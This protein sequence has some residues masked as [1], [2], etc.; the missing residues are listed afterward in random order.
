MV[1]QTISHYRIVEK[2]GGGGMGVVYKAEDIK[3]NRF[4][5]LKFLPE[6][7]AHDPHALERFRREAKAASAL[8]HPNICTIY[9][10][11]EQNGQAFIA[12]EFMDGVT[13]KHR[14]GGKPMEI[15][16][17]LSLGI[18]IADA[19]DSAHSAGIVHRDIKPANIFVTKRGHAKILD[20]GLAKVTAVLSDTGEAGATAPSTVTLEDHLTSPGTAVG[21]VAYMSPEQV[22][23]QRLNERTDLF[24]FGVVLYEMAT[25]RRPFERE[26]MGATFGAILHESPDPPGRWNDQ[27]PGGLQEIILK[28]LAKQQELRYQRALE[29]RADLQR[30]E[31]E[32]ESTQLVTSSERVTRPARYAA[33]DRRKLLYAIALVFGFLVASAYLYLRRPPKFTEKDTLVISDFINSSDDPVFD[34]TLR[35]GL[36]VQLEQSPF[37]NIV[38]DEKVAQTLR[39][40]SQP[41][42]VRLSPQIARELCQRTE[43][44]AVLDGSIAQIG[45]QYNLIVKAVNCATGES[46]ASAEA[47]ATDKNHVLDALGKVASQIRS[48]L[49]ESLSTIQK[50]DTPVEQAT[51]PSLEALQ[52]YTLAERTTQEKGDDAAAIPLY[53]RAIR[54]DPNFAMAYA[55]LGSSYSNLLELGL[56]AENTRRAYELRSRVSEREELSIES[57]YHNNVTGD[58][59]KARQAY[60][61]WAKTYPRDGVPVGNLSSVYA[62]LGQYD[63]ALAEAREAVRLD[64]KSAFPYASVVLSYLYLNRLDEARLTAEE[65]QS[66]DLDSPPLHVF[67]YQVAFLQNDAQGMAK[68]VTWSTGKPLVEAIVLSQESETAAYFGHLTRAR[69]LSR[70]AVAS[71]ERAG[72]K[73]AAADIEGLAALHEALLGSATEARQRAA[74]ALRR[75][76]GRDAQ[77]EAALCLAMEGDAPRAQVLVDDLAQRFPEDTVVQFNCLPTIR[78]QLALNRIDSPTAVRVLGFAVPYELGSFP[79]SLYP[80]YLRGTAYLAG[81]H[82]AEA[83]AEFQKILEYRAIVGNES[84]GAL[85]H[86]QLGRAYA[87]SNDTVKAKA[88]YERLFTL[89]KDADSDIPILKEA[90][91]EYAKLQ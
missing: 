59:E 85:A 62:Q 25:G 9:E 7:V 24:S 86:A 29:M 50:F 33:I 14:I 78:A 83:A 56:A 76:T 32:S 60:E 46:L 80:V 44:T 63:K 51:T 45:T 61:L 52:A 54:L 49:G 47:R 40:M 36:A 73:E 28:A 74:S 53:Q 20:F 21:T 43:S 3:L 71:A 5:A 77:C 31:R 67:L 69:E 30:I 91:M 4:V 13:L 87:L 12:M 89:W 18:E 90:K 66:K 65:A 82:G 72:D 34:G 57:R 84:I 6:D 79:L 88:A 2:L 19:L 48:K 10:I 38:S 22:A 26:T 1:G 37:L 42:D 35:Q 23:G 58:L 8:N 11:D 17:V 15:E 41:P 64:P 55:D 75:S 68:Q 16:T 27:L 70:R 39:F 81:H